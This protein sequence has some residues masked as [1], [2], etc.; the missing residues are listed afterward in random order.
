MKTVTLTERE[1]DA[2]YS[3]IRPYAEGIADLKNSKGDNTC[4]K[5][6]KRRY[7]TAEEAGVILEK[8]EED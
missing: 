1:R 5:T 2:L 4:F 3:V 7:I 6:N 8:L